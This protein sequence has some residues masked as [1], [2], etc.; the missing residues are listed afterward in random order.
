MKN[1]HF[2]RFIQYVN[3]DILLQERLAVEFVALN[4][5]VE[6]Q[7]VFLCYSSAVEEVTTTLAAPVALPASA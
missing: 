2:S 3:L 1:G 5:K 4:F 7:S 6:S